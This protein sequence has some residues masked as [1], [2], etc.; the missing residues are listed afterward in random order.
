MD[1]LDF[2]ADELY[3]DE[4]LSEEVEGCIQQAA[5]HYGDSA[6]EHLLLRAYFLEPEHPSVL[7]ALYR[8]FYYQHRYAEALRIANRVLTLF[9]DRLGLPDSW[10]LVTKED[11]ENAARNSMVE[12]R[13][14]LLALK[15]SGYLLLR[16]KNFDVAIEQFRKL[17][18]VDEKDRLGAASLLEMAEDEFNR[19]AGIY[20]LKF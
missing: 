13:F 10:R 12:L 17:V 15:G 18:E 11:I 20:R 6:T 2:E 9:A 3:F 5:E 7:V 16:L 8:Y 14:Y 19:Q 4:P 1:L